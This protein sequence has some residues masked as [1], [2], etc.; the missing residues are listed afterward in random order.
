MMLACR[1]LHRKYPPATT[2][3]GGWLPVTLE[4]SI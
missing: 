1:G 4:T 2:I 3:E